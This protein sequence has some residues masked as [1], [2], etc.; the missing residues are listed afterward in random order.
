MFAVYLATR[1]LYRD[2]VML[3]ALGAAALALLI[4]A[5]SVVWSQFPNDVHFNRDA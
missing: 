2:R 1:L 5:G 4:V 3:N